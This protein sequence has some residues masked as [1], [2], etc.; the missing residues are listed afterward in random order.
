MRRGTGRFNDVVLGLRARRKVEA[1]QAGGACDL[2]ESNASR[3][4]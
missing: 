1:A 3:R 2:R 4:E